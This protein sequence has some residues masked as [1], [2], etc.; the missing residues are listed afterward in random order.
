MVQAA[1]V[2]HWIKVD[3]TVIPVIPE[4]G[5]R[6]SLKELQD[7]VGGYVERLGLPKRAVMI[8]NEEGIP[9]G[10]PFNEKASQIAG[11]EIVGD[12]VVLP[13]GMGW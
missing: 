7:M 6:F 10:L 13:R 2:A 12:V 4:K 3:G 9:K 1:K 5:A 8:L 11:R